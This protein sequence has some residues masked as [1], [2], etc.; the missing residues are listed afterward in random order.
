M[1]KWACMLSEHDATMTLRK[2]P[3]ERNAE[4]GKGTRTCG[5]RGN[6]WRF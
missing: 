3:T 6:G 2:Q 5:R 1:A 4:N